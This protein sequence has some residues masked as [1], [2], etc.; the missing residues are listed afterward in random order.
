MKDIAESPDHEIEPWT[1]IGK[2]FELSIV[3]ILIGMVCGFFATLMSKHMRF[4]THSPVVE[5]SLLLAWALLGYFVSELAGMSAI[6]TLLV[7]SII[8]SHYTWYNLSP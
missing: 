5:S 4:L 6:C 2:F 3:S 1:I 8:F 7:A